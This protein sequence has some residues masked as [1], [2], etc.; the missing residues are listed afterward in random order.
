MADLAGPGGRPLA[1]LRAALEDVLKGHPSL[2]LR[3]GAALFGTDPGRFARKFLRMADGRLLPMPGDGLRV[4]Q[5]CRH[6]LTEAERTE[7]AAASLKGGDM[8][9]LGELMN[10]SHQSCAQDYEISCYEL[11]QLVDLM[12][13]AGALGARLTGAGFGGFA[14]GLVRADEAE[15]VKAA[16]E[17]GFY[18]P[19]RI[20]AAQHLFLFQ[21][22]DGALEE[23]LG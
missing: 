12:R 13:G 3:W 14:I 9:G 20:A 5:R 17:R 6:V 18:A 7:R 22:A 4:L 1:E 2:S 10:E 19:R 8:R 11:D 16:L 21:P 23:P 15:Q